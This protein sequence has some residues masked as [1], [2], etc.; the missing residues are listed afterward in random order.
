M[1]TRGA[2]ETRFDRLIEIFA[3]P[4]TEFCTRAKKYAFYR[5]H[6]QIEDFSDLFVTE[7]LI[8]A[9]HE[10]HPLGFREPLNR[11][12]DRLL[13]FRLQK[14]CVRREVCLVFQRRIFGAWL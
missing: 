1:R 14:R 3:E 9:Q 4:G 12:L 6:R 13:Q 11:I 8:P 5:R 2:T 10:R 7:L